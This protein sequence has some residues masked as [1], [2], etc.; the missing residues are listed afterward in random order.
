[1]TGQRGIIT[2]KVNINNDLLSSMSFFEDEDNYKK[3][4]P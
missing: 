2:S 4:K 3:A 1:M